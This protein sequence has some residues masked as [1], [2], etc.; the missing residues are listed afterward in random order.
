M[1]EVLL[2]PTYTFRNT[3]SESR[4]CASF[5]EHPLLE[6]LQGRHVLSWAGQGAGGQLLKE[7]EDKEK[8]WSWNGRAPG[9]EEWLQRE[10]VGV[11]H[12]WQLKRE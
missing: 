9:A 1:S 7:G 8:C 6:R 4:G 3:I 11:G 5:L 10:C 12:L 2:G